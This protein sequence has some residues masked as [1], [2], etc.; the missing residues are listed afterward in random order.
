MPPAEDNDDAPVTPPDSPAAI[1]VAK[2]QE[3]AQA[4]VN[5]SEAGDSGAAAAAASAYQ[6]VSPAYAPNPADIKTQFC[7]PITYTK[8]SDDVLVP[9]GCALITNEN[10]DELA[11]GG[12]TSAAYICSV[13]SNPVNINAVKLSDLGLVINGVSDISYIQPGPST[14]IQW[15]VQDNQAGP[16]ATWTSGWHP[17]LTNVHL[18]GIDQGNDAV[19]SLVMKSTATSVKIPSVCQSS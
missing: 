18:H 8:G 12:S 2:A 6:P 7:G 13:D 17:D 5:A 16:S 10:V 4:A 19:L 9:A 3:A 1:Q 14:S 15:F 11:D